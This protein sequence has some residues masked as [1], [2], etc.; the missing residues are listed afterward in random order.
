MDFAI[1]DTAG[2]GPDDPTLIRLRGADPL[3]EIP[4]SHLFRRISQQR[5]ENAG[6]ACTFVSLVKPAASS[7][8]PSAQACSA[9]SLGPPRATARMKP[10]SG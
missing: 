5:L 10:S 8:Q 3:I 2:V 7:S 4:P 6:S 1:P 9:D